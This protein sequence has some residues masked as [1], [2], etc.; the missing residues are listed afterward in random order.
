MLAAC[1]GVT[2][3]RRYVSLELS[4]SLVVDIDHGIRALDP[5]ATEKPPGYSWHTRLAFVLISEDS[6]RHCAR[7]FGTRFLN[8]SYRTESLTQTYNV[9]RLR[10]T[11]ATCK[12][13]AVC[14]TLG[15]NDIM[16][17]EHNNVEWVSWITMI[18]WKGRFMC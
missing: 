7:S 4:G 15:L 11:T 1:L 9:Y 6:M 12:S 16:P 10:L 17:E 18:E 2:I 8:T 3:T 14:C 13:P 5:K